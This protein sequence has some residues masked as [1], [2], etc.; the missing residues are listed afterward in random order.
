MLYEAKTEHGRSFM[1]RA[2]F[3]SKKLFGVDG[4][5]DGAKC[6]TIQDVNFDIGKVRKR[7]FFQLENSHKCTA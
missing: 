6:R 7:L 1:T 5:M 2:Y 3:S 4:M